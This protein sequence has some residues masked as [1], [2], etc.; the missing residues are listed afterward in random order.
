[1]EDGNIHSLTQLALYVETFGRFDVLE[2]D[3]T[4][5]GFEGC[6]DVYE[7]LGVGLVDF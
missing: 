2:Y 1:M 3:A 7:L 4:E 6:D 5:S